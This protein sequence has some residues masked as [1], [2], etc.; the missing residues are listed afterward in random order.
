MEDNTIYENN[1]VCLIYQETQFHFIS[2]TPSSPFFTIFHKSI[3]S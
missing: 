2:Y 3:I 1:N